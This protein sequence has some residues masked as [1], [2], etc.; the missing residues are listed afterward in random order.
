MLVG[1]CS[2]ELSGRKLHRKIKSHKLRPER[3]DLRFPRTLRGNVFDRGAMGLRP[4]KVMKNAICP[5]PLP[6]EAPTSPLS[7]RPSVPGFPAK[8]HLTRP[9]YRKFGVAW[10]RALPWRAVGSAVSFS[11]LTHPTKPS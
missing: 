5:R 7:S 2:W 1:K 10:W 11:V 8:R 9:R 6:L 4:T 3:R